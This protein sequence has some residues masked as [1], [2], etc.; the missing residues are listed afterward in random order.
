VVQLLQRELKK[1]NSKE[2]LSILLVDD[3]Q[4]VLNISK[5]LLMN[6][7]N[8]E[9][10]SSLSVDEAIQKLDKQKYDAIVSDYEMP[11]KTG[12]D[13]LKELKLQKNE[14]AFIL[15]T[16]KGNEEVAAT[17][18]NFGA[19]G[20]YNKEGPVETVY[21]E[22]THAIRQLVKR[23]HTL[24]NLRESKHPFKKVHNYEPSLIYRYDLSEHENI[25]E[26][27]QEGAKN[28]ET[29]V[30]LEERGHSGSMPT[31]KCACGD[32]ILVI[33][34]LYAM[35]RA[36]ENHVTKHRR[37]G[38]NDGK[39]SDGYVDVKELLIKQLLKAISELGN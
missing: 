3:D 26:F 14:S 35:N 18:L 17:A 5:Q 24:I 20:Y 12:L 2:R 9:V 34:D 11:K 33:P 36:I 10:D 31:I 1:V 19:D 23:K 16:G 38:L 37:T 29:H 32:Q 27:N 15:F 6:L 7:G 28:G 13:F 4:S 25:Y 30:S 21:T 39:E 22:L 8:F